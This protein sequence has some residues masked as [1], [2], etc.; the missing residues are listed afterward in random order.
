MKTC[1]FCKKA[2]S[3]HYISQPIGFDGQ[4]VETDIWIGCAEEEDAIFEA[5]HDLDNQWIEEGIEEEIPF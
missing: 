4:V 5:G 1:R 3:E 2:E